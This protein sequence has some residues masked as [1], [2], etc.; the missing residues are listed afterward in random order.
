MTAPEYHGVRFGD[1]P[2]DRRRRPD[3]G[4]AAAVRRLGRFLGAGWS[5]HADQA[6][7]MPGLFLTG[8]QL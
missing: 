7:R 1:R 3:S 8:G 4:P 6:G 5:F 2:Q